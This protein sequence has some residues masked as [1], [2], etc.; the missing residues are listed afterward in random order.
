MTYL[1][2]DHVGLRELAGLVVVAA[3]EPALQ[4][5]EERRVEID[6][7]VV[8]AIERPH[9][10]ARGTAGRARGAGKHHQRRRP[11][12]AALLLENVTPYHLGA[13]QHGGYELPGAI[14]RCAGMRRRMV[15]RVIGMAAVAEDLRAADQEPR[16][17]A[18][19]PADQPEH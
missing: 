18:E 10:G 6:P 15:R 2:G 8:R 11:V 7:L 14:A 16:I 4:V 17:D 13:A 9:G 19:R 1:M 12:A 5:A 3:V